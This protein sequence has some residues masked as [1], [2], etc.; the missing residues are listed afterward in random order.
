MS[1]SP[2]V[3]AT[4]R[5]LLAWISEGPR[6]YRETMDAWGTSC[7][8]LSVWEDAIGDGLVEIVRNGVRSEPRV[9]LSGPGQAVLDAD[10]PRAAT[11]R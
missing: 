5:E 3:T 10:P 9:V 2:G 11:S 7:P 1:A 8:R 6:T 4:R